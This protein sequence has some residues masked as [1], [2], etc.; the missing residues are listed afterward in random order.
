MTERM[1]AIASMGHT[2][3]RVRCALFAGSVDPCRDLEIIHNEL[4]KKDIAI[5]QG[6]IE[7]MRRNVER[8]LGGKEA[9]EEFQTLEKVLK[10]M[11]DGQEVRNGEWTG[12]EIEVLNKY[13]L[14]TA[15]PVIYLVNLS[16]R[17][18]L[19]KKNKFLPALAEWM[20]ARGSDDKVIPFSC[21][22]EAKV[23]GEYVQNTNTRSAWLS[24][25]FPLFFF[26]ACERT[27]H[28]RPCF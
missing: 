25:H 27:K 22:F 11:E 14:L 7:S 20:K 15:K 10:T 4:L 26:R 24:V 9:K 5:L 2:H 3:A 21:E 13:Q 17:D 19:R 23:R 12:V 6:K 28:A 16:E 8:G 1:L 18:F